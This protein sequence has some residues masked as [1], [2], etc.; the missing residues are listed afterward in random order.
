MNVGRDKDGIIMIKTWSAT[1][2]KGWTAFLQLGKTL[3][4]C[5]IHPGQKRENKKREFERG[6]A[7]DILPIINVHQSLN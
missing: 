6:K 2:E 5:R 3:S 4:S 1:G 7:R